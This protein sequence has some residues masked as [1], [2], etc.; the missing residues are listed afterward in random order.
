MKRSLLTVLL[1]LTFVTAQAQ[2]WGIKFGGFLKTD[3]IMNTRKNLD[4]RDGEL[5]FY[6]LRENKDANG[7]DINEVLNV[8]MLSFQ[9]RLI[10]NITAPDFL[11]AKV[12]GTLESEFFGTTDGDINGMRLRHAVIKLD[13]GT[14][15]LFIGQYWNPLFFEDAFP[16]VIQYN[17]GAPYIP[18]TRNPQIRYILAP[19]EELEFNLTAMSQRDF[20]SVG[21]NGGSVEYLKFSGIPMMNFGFRYK[22]SS[23]LFLGGN[24]QYKVLKPRTATT[25]GFKTDETV[26]G[27]TANAAIK[28]SPSKDFFATIEGTYAQN[29]TDLLL[30]GGYIGVVTDASTGLEKYYATNNLSVAFDTQYGTKWMIG[31]FAGYSMNMGFSEEQTSAFTFYGRS[32]DIDNMM[33]ISPRLMYRDG[34]VQL[35]AELDYSSVAYGTVNAKTG[36]VENTTNVSNIRFQLAGYL[37]F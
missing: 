26:A 24:A 18:F 22:P 23:A 29:G 19:T 6:P 3:V 1:A 20:T 5:Y 7:D 13:W 36:K 35:G 28:V 21:P 17:T 37:F 32:A 14:S 4:I 27:I 31:L 10:G 8:N 11:G 9:S 12:S 15:K 2:D 33:R 25:K 30:Q 16:K 34:S